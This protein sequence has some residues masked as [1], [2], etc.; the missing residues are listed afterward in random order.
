MNVYVVLKK[1]FA[2]ERGFR[3][4]SLGD[5]YYVE[6]VMVLYLWAGFARKA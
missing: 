1:C 3:M 4:I 2:G 5:G 6:S